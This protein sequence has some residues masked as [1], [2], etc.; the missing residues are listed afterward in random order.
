[1]SG[2][3]VSKRPATFTEADLRRVIRVGKAEGAARVEYTAKDGTKVVYDL[4]ERTPDAVDSSP[5]WQARSGM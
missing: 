3:E 2:R 1:M 4:K 5:G